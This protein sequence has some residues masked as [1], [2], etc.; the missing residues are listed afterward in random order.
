MAILRTILMTVMIS[1]VSNYSLLAE[2]LNLKPFQGAWNVVELIDS[3]IEIS[4]DEFSE[5]LHSGGQ[6][7]I[8]GDQIIFHSVLDGRQYSKTLKVD[9]RRTPPHFNV[10]LIGETTGWGIYQF[11]GDQL[12]VCMSGESATARPKELTSEEGSSD[13]LMVL[14]RDKSRPQTTPKTAVR[15]VKPSSPEAEEEEQ[16]AVKEIKQQDLIPTDLKIALALVGTWNV[17][18]EFSP[19]YIWLK[20]DG[21]FITSRDVPAIRTF[22][23]IFYNAPVSSGHWTVSNGVLKL[24]ITNSLNSQRVGAGLEFAVHNLTPQRVVFVS[25]L[26]ASVG[27]VRVR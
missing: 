1:L 22:V 25:H 26:G 2:D 24:Q 3:G 15:P 13:V 23:F 27:A 21:T 7:H 8:Q 4:H 14:K 16:V 12:T 10:E 9:N 11:D 19:F 6:F 5:L 20:Q 17:P 18:Q